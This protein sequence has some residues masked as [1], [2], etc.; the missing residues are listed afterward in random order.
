MAIPKKPSKKPEEFIASAKI[1]E[2][3]EKPQV[4]KLLIE[5][6]Y[7]VWFSLKMRALKEGK[8]LKDLITEILSENA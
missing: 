1:K 6:P 4:K 2:G 7:D 5:L 8:T 3:E